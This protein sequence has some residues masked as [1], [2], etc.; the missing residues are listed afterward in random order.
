MVTDDEQYEYCP[1]CDANLTLQ[2]GYSN[3]L[4]YWVCKGCGEMLINPDVD[5][6]DDVAWICD[7]CGAMLNVQEGFA[8]HADKWTC[9]EC[10][11][12]NNIDEKNL[13]DTEESYLAD[14][15]N[16]YKGLEDSEVLY[17]TSYKELARVGDRGDILLVEDPDSGE[18]YIKKYLTTY[19]K[20]IYEYLKEHPVAHM[21]RVLY[22]AES[23]N[24]L[25]VLEEFIKGRTLAQII[26]EDEITE[27]MAL[28]VARKTCAVLKDIHNLPKPIVHRDIKP[29]NIILTDEG[30]I[31][32][33]DMNAAKWYKPDANDDTNYLGTRLFAAPEQVG[34]GLKAS[35][36]KSDIY[37]LG[38]LMNVMLTG[39][40]PK[41]KQAPEPY[42]G[43]IEKC[44]S[45]E[46]DARYNA[47][48][49][50]D[51]LEKISRRGKDNA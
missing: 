14:L 24:C 12:E 46:A 20:S 49:L 44:I 31:Y 16:P 45:L 1:R 15:M 7:R 35:S 34:Y 10:G 13:Y 40:V 32:L 51:V 23:S 33:L 22:L 29:S 5:A 6:D 26:C 36:A 30:E 39:D 50:S 18:V 42:W 3:T 43:V 37:A 47:K 41:Q 8:D 19:D 27:D 28:T 2:K 25:I 21:P 4:P 38:V 48:E 11:Y 17:I 9:T